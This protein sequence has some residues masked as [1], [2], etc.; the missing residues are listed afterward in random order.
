M[1][2]NCF[3]SIVCGLALAS[4]PAIAQAQTPDADICKND[5]RF[6]ALDYVLGDWDVYSGEAKTAEVKMELILNDCVIKETWTVINGRSTGNGIGLFNYSP[7]LS[8]WG[9]YWATDNGSTTSFRGMLIEPGEMRFITERPLDEGKMRLRHWTLYAMEDGT[10][11]EL[12]VGTEG[13]DQGWTTEYD[14]RW[15]RKP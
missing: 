11:R 4:L 15:V 9:Y 7:L 10:I 13:A 12:S 2:H 5:P 6:R 1:R 3:L 14:L 8:N